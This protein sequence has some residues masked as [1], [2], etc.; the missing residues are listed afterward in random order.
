MKDKRKILEEL[1]K[2]IEKIEK[3]S[4]FNNEEIVEIIADNVNARRGK[5]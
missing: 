3:E 5:Y 4:D 2:F 1:Q